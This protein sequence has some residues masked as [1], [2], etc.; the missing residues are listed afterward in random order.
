VPL[1]ACPFVFGV[2]LAG[3]LVIFVDGV[4]EADVNIVRAGVEFGWNQE[5]DYDDHKASAGVRDRIV[6]TTR[7]RLESGA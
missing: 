5:Q 7:V 3:A 2:G 4:D 6:V 1:L